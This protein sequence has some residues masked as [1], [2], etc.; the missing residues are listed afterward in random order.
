HGSGLMS[1]S[2]TGLE[3]FHKKFDLPLDGVVHTEAPYFYRRP[4]ADMSEGD[5]TKWLLAKLE[6]LIQRE[7]PDTIA[8]FIGE[9]VLGT[10]GIVPPP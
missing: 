7:D 4:E 5:F 6:E 3:L 8:A 2:L 9:P 10:G 1:G